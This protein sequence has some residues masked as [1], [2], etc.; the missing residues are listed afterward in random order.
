[1]CL[2]T[3]VYGGL[4]AALALWLKNFR[5]YTKMQQPPASRA[6]RYHRPRKIGAVVKWVQIVHR[7][8][9]SL[10]SKRRQSLLID[11]YH[12]SRELLFSFFP[13][14]EPDIMHEN[15]A[16]G[17]IRFRFRDERQLCEWPDRKLEVYI[18]YVCSSVSAIVWWDLKNYQENAVAWTWIFIFITPRRCLLCLHSV[19]QLLHRPETQN[20]LNW[21][22][23]ILGNLY[24]ERIRLWIWYTDA[25]TII[26]AGFGCEAN[27]GAF[28]WKRE[29]EGEN[30]AK[31]KDF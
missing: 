27:L 23:T 28:N 4:T 5:K 6:T 15:S 9:C 29:K 17:G 24:G 1:M 18:L 12:V 30:K 31:R 25:M 16:G 8:V 22:D 20:P 14:F 2:Y 7:V 21:T 26:P 3:L 13:P 19:F 11:R 10:C